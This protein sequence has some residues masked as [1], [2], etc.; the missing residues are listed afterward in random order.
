M[1]YKVD[2]HPASVYALLVAR[3]WS[4]RASSLI[5]QPS[6]TG[7][8]TSELLDGQGSFE[9]LHRDHQGSV[10]S[11]SNAAGALVSQSVYDPF[12]QQTILWSAPTAVLN[13]RGYTG[14]RNLANVGIIH[15]GGRIYDP[16]LGGLWPAVALLQCA[17]TS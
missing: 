8:F 12:G 9:L 1:G 5:R 3:L 7:R 10:V 2:T 4:N 11:I 17:H 14:H 15:M 6:T 16:R 13:D